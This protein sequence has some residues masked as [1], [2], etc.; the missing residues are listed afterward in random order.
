MFGLGTSMPRGSA[1]HETCDREHCR[2][3]RA[4]GGIEAFLGP[5]VSAR[6]EAL[7]SDYGFHAILFADSPF[8]PVN[9]RGLKARSG[10]RNHLNRARAGRAGT[11]KAPREKTALAGGN[12]AQPLP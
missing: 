7:C 12:P 8:V 3:R 4:G 5:H 10:L 9:P 6:V 2:R 1:N 11:G